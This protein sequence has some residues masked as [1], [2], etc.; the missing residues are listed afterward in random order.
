MLNICSSNIIL[1]SKTMTEYT[2]MSEINERDYT[3]QDS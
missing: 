2:N 1:F 3:F